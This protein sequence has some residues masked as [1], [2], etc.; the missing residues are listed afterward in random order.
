MKLWVALGRLCVF[1]ENIL[2]EL[3]FHLYEEWGIFETSE[4]AQTKIIP[5]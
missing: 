4:G 1:C 3:L 2:K 5:H